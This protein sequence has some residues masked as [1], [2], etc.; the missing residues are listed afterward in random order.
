[1]YFSYQNQ[2]FYNR[3][4]G[5]IE[6]MV[7]ITIITLVSAIVIAKH[8]AF[9]G[10]VLLRNQTYEVAFA[11][12]QAQLLAVSGSNPNTSIKQRYGVYFSK[13]S[14]NS[15]LVYRD[16][17]ANGRYEA[18]DTQIGPIGFI[19]RRFFIREIFYDTSIGVGNGEVNNM[20]VSFVRPNFDAL[21]RRS[22][23]PYQPG[24]VYIDIA[25]V[26]ET[27]NGIGVVRR[28]EVTATGQVSITEY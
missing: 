11:L 12:R 14:Q 13:S 24:P 2:Q 17:D 18:S 26:G 28:V 27:G 10:A 20:S 5:L 22:G 9:N 25:R 21:F 23:G 1:M 6:L 7:S 15:Y 19:D 8:N 16:N 4:F 3:G